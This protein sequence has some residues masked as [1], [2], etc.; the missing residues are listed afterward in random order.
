MK[1]IIL[2]FTLA[3]PVC[4]T[5]QSVINFEDLQVPSKGYWNGSDYAGQFKSGNL[6]FNN[7]YDTT[8]GEYWTGFAY[9]N[10]KNDSTAGYG[11]QYASYAGG[12]YQSA[13]YAIGYAGATIRFTGSDAGKAA[14]GYYVTNSTYTALSMKNGDSFAKKFGGQS[15]DEPD[16]FGLLMKTYS[17]GSFRTDSVWLADYRNAD[18]SKDF[19]QKDWLWVDLSSKGNIDSILFDFFSS[20]TNSFGINTPTYFCID[21]IITKGT[22][23]ALTSPSSIST[24]QIF[25]NPANDFIQFSGIPANAWIQAS[26]FT[27]TGQHV[28]TTPL[29]GEQKLSIE[30]LPS[31]YYFIDLKSEN[32]HWTARFI[33]P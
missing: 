7:T 22:Y 15:G 32:G 6:V 9:S 24:A 18:N 31:G 1:K 23:T 26:V 28:M 2:F 19:I 27:S 12:G 17:G 21:Q 11:N 8:F 4:A 14:E 20:D 3:L 33:K 5:S 25:P 29:F 16:Y 30:T 10:I 13:N